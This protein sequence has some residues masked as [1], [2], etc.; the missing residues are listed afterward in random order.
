[1]TSK[2][3]YSIIQRRKNSVSKSVNVSY[4]KCEQ[5]FCTE[6]EQTSQQSSVTEECEILQELK[7]EL[8]KVRMENIKTENEI[9]KLE[10]VKNEVN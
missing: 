8:E 1:M 5:S 4:R 7:Q 6:I 2:A 3:S 10:Q 9:G